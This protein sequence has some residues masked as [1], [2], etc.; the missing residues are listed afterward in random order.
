MVSGGVQV[1]SLNRRSLKISEVYNAVKFI[2]NG[3]LKFAELYKFALSK[4]S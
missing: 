2:F 3:S 1:K 4:R